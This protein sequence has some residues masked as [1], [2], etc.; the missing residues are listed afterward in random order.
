[1]VKFGRHLQ[2]YLESVEGNE[3]HGNQKNNI[4]NNIDDDINNKN[5]DNFLIQKSSSFEKYGYKYEDYDDQN[6]HHNN[7]STS[8]SNHYIVPYSRL[9]NAIESPDA[10]AVEVDKQQQHQQHHNDQ[11]VMDMT[12]SSFEL[13]WRE[14]LQKSN[15]DFFESINSCWKSVFESISDK[16]NKNVM[17]GI[18]LMDAIHVYTQMKDIVSSRDLLCFL[19]DTY[20]IAEMNYQA[21]RK[22]VKKFDK[23][24]YMIHG[25]SYN[26]NGGELLSSSLL[27]ELYS[28]TL[29]FGRMT[30]KMAI[31]NLRLIIEEMSST[32]SGSDAGSD[33]NNHNNDDNNNI[34]NNPHQQGE[35]NLTTDDEFDHRKQ[36]YLTTAMLDHHMGNKNVTLPALIH[37]KSLQHQSSKQPNHHEQD[38][39]DLD[40]EMVVTNKRANEILWLNDIVKSTPQSELRHIVAHRGFHTSQ[41]RSDYRPLE[42]SL[43]AFETAWSAGIHLC[44][45]DVA[46][47]K[48]EKLVLAHD[49]DF[50]R[51]ALD[52]SSASSTLKVSE[53]TFKELIA[54]TLKNGVRAPLLKDVL[55]SANAI[56]PEAKL[57]I[58]IKPGNSEAAMALARLLGKYPELM[59]HVAVIMSFD[60]WSMHSLCDELR[61]SFPHLVKGESSSSSFLRRPNSTSILGSSPGEY[62]FL[63]DRSKRERTDSL[64]NYFTSQKVS[65]PK[66]MLLTVADLPENRFELCVDVSDYSPIDG[67]LHSTYTSLEG[68]YVQF[69]PEMLLPEGK[70]ALQK[71][72]E[73][74]IVGI[75]GKAGKDPDDRRTIHYL[76]KECGVSFI[77]TDL[78]RTF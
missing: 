56:G 68:V 57:I 72:T 58:E 25:K 78:P 27:P 20:N 64:V 59:G 44:E 1:M 17:R 52:K 61:K 16:N 9:R 31:D 15:S 49:E 37:P 2:F 66:L 29:Y 3:G 45:C 71:L 32:P 36:S 42:N 62:S 54:L 24:Y 5:H 46:L 6:H 55:L 23:K 28:S 48:D 53:L 41:G 7:T 35:L 13:A 75:W 63:M 65:L 26:N 8:L 47:T 40:E 60:L 51:L 77:N 39:N 12:P 43:S 10:E 33:T 70:A 67:W 19:K 74:Y 18:E 30:L 22:I 34:S 11:N 73:K 21:L 69:Q 50:N 38:R 14:A 4:D 76:L